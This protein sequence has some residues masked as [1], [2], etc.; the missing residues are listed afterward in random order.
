MDDEQRADGPAGGLWCFDQ[1]R[2]LPGDVV[3]ERGHGKF[4]PLITAVDRGRYSHALI[5]IGGGEFLEA[6]KGGV[7]PIGFARVPVR[8]PANWLA[9]RHPNPAAGAAAAVVSRSMAHRGYDLLGALTSITPF[10]RLDPTRLF[11]S[12]LVATAYERAGYPLLADLSPHQVTPNM[13]IRD[14]CLEP[15]TPPPLIEPTG[16]VRAVATEIMNRDRAYGASPMAAEMGVVQAVFALI[17]PMYPAIP[18]P[19]WKGLTSPPADLY[20]AMALL[21]VLDEPVARAISDRLVDELDRR[22]YFHLADGYLAAAAGR[23]LIERARLNVGS[24]R[25]LDLP[26]LAAGLRALLPGRK[27]ALARHE[28]NAAAYDEILAQRRL[29]LFKRLRHMHAMIAI[30]LQLILRI[31]GE[32][33]AECERRLGVP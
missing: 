6:V 33:L 32:I 11:C 10:A 30:H 26:V 27:A 7:R 25:D 9:L 19:P 13:L 24:A 1:N 16:A 28:A 21:Q 15:V 5:W 31:E 22:G 17:R 12:Q 2:L 20:E 14:A 23:R 29:R 18:M 8:E 3:L 4:S